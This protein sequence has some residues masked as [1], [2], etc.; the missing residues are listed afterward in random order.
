MVM[1]HQKAMSASSV[2]ASETDI[3]NYQSSALPEPLYPVRRQ[4]LHRSVTMSTAI[5]TIIPDPSPQAISE[6]KYVYSNYQPL[7]D[8]FSELQISKKVVVGNSAAI[9]TTLAVYRKR[10]RLRCLPSLPKTGKS[11]YTYQRF[12]NLYL[13]ISTVVLALVTIFVI[14][15]IMITKQRPGPPPVAQDNSTVPVYQVYRTIDS[16]DGT[17]PKGTV[18]NSMELSIR[19][20]CSY[21]LN[22]TSIDAFYS[23]SCTAAFCFNDPGILTPQVLS[24]CTLGKLQEH[25]KENIGWMEDSFYCRWP[26]INC[27]QNQTVIS[28]E[29]N[30]TAPDS[31][32]D[33]ITNFYNLVNLTVIGNYTNIG[34]FL[35][36][37]LFL[38]ET[39]SKVH[40]KSVGY[41]FRIPNTNSA[42]VD[43]DLDTLPGWDKVLPA[44]NGLQKFSLKNIPIGPSIFTFLN[45]ATD[46]TNS[47]RTL[48][49]GNLNSTYNLNPFMFQQLEYLDITGIPG[50]KT[51]AC[52]WSKARQCISCC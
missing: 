29:F 50:E 22:T 21:L 13:P 27:D 52:A 18:L 15:S 6:P 49:L 12:W 26:G 25:I 46:W 16:P 41:Q 3:Y 2:S 48:T 34:G 40:L 36:S 47:L 51:N 20:Q 5:T 35:P 45:N 14:A 42:L 1:G 43:L 44:I 33:F 28:L 19:T 10:R 17:I 31:I 9:V 24:I 4:S 30:G 39:I 8:T 11:L 38:I 32:P 23:Q 7:K 37:E